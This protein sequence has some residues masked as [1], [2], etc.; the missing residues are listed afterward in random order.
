MAAIASVGITILFSAQVTNPINSATFQVVAP[1]GK[2]P[3]CASIQEAISSVFE[4]KAGSMYAGKMGQFW[5][6][7]TL[8]GTGAGLTSYAQ[9][10]TTALSTAVTGLTSTVGL[11]VG[12]LVSGPNITVAPTTI[13]AIPSSTTIT[14]SAAATTA[15]ATTLY[16]TPPQAYANANEVGQY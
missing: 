14:L 11:G 5:T 8:N 12:W 15:S 9:P 6:A 13:A 3:V 4:G 16:F 7:Q 1:W 10:A 2:S